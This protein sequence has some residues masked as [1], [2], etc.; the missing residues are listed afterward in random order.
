MSNVS[1]M[2]RPDNNFEIVARSGAIWISKDGILGPYVVQGPSIYPHIDGM[3]QH[4]LGNLED[5][6]IWLQRRLLP[7]HG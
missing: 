2:L 3:P 1:I 7:Y 5:P 6:V 4:N